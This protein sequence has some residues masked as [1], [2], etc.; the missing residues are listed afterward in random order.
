M[1]GEIGIILQKLLRK[2]ESRC[3]IVKERD[4][5]LIVKVI[6]GI[7]CRIVPIVFDKF[8][9]EFY[10][11]FVIIEKGSMMYKIVFY[12]DKRGFSETAEFVKELQQKE[13]KDSKIN[14]HKIVAYLNSLEKFGTRI[15]TPVTKYLGEEIWELRPLKNRILYAYFKDDTFVLLTH[16]IKKTQKTPRKEL[17]RAKRCLKDYR[18]RRL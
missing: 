14:F 11:K 16:F 5:I 13:D 17:E 2:L 12:E 7:I 1:N 18:E 4:F 9:L 3:N 10:N 8:K 6:K 15:G